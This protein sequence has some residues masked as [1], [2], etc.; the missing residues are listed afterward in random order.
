MFFKKGKIITIDGVD[1]PGNKIIFVNIT[2]GYAILSKNF[3]DWPGRTVDEDGNYPV[4]LPL[5]VLPELAAAFEEC[6]KNCRLS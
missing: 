4:Q 3:K 5:D 1:I 2:T 6:L